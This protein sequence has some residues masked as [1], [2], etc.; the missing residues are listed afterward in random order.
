LKVPKWGRFAVSGCV[1]ASILI[2]VVKWVGVGRIVEVL[3]RLNPAW[4]APAIAL[5]LTAPVF[6]A[7]RWKLLLN[8]LGSIS[9]RRLTSVVILGSLANTLAPA[10]TGEFLRALLIRGQG[11]VRFTSG[12]SSIFAERVLDVLA[13]L[14]LSAAG[15]AA[16]QV[17]LPAMF[18]NA[19]RVVGALFVALTALIIFA[20][21]KGGLTL[22]ALRAV[23][24]MFPERVRSRLTG[25]VELAVKGVEA[26]N[27]KPKTILSISIL[28]VVVWLVPA[29]STIL[30]FKAFSVEMSLG[31]VTLGYALHSLSF[32]IPAPPGYAGTFEVYWAL[33]YSNL[34]MRFEEA[35]ALGLTVHV[36]SLL[37]TAALGSLAL[38]PLNPGKLVEA[39]EKGQERISRF[40]W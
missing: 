27:E 10:R 20:A 30:L 24:R 34:G 9:L 17:T 8:P 35:L 4:L 11:D 12:L 37:T 19:L 14:G 3:G 16:A 7:V 31:A 25:Q 32:A 26:L 15:L 38:L 13:L 40:G 28:T 6:R 2:V 39:M 36:I 33:I 22:N 1:G 18:L 23:E 21:K 29:A 5:S